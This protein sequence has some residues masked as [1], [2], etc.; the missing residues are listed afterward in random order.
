[1][2]KFQGLMIGSTFVNNF[3]EG[4][5]KAITEDEEWKTFFEENGVTAAMAQE[6]ANTLP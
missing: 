4:I 2:E 3:A 1:M 6:V 5:M